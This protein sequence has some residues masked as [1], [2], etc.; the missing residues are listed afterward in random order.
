[1]IALKLHVKCA[2]S[3]GHS[4]WFK[5]LDLFRWRLQPLCHDHP[6]LHTFLFFNPP[7]FGF[8]KNQ[9]QLVQV[10][11]R[12]QRRTRTK[13][14]LGLPTLTTRTKWQ[15]GLEMPKKMAKTTTATLE[16]LPRKMTE[17][18]RLLLD[19]A[20][21]MATQTLM[22]GA[23]PNE[24]QQSWPSNSCKP[25]RRSACG[26]KRKRKP[27]GSGSRKRRR[28]VRSLKLNAGPHHKGARA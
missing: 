17:T 25:K 21:A 9:T 6:H 3:G 14:R 7:A 27:R 23:S 28:I 13:R 16:M 20:A 26:R 4:S 15:G 1:M 10:L 12:K 24:L 5:A 22:Q 11:A 2:F 19:L 8:H 18:A